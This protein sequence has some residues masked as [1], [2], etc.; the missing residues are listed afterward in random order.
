M[1]QLEI[2]KFLEEHRD[3]WKSLLTSDPYNLTIR[4]RDNFIL[5]MY[6]QIDSD[7]N[8]PLVCECRG[9]ILEKDTFKVICFPFTKFWNAQEGK[10]ASLDWATAKVQEK[11]DGS[12]LKSF[13]YDG[14]WRFS[15]M[16]MIDASECTLQNDL[17]NRYPTFYSLFMEGARKACLNFDRLDKN[18]TYMFE[19]VSPYNRVVVPY[20]EIEIYHTGT[21][22]N[23]TLEELEVDIGVK[24]PKSYSFSNEA[25]VLDMATHLP[26]SEEGYVVV[27]ANWNRVKV[28][29]PAYVAIHH[30][31]NNGDINKKRAL[32]IIMLNEHF[33]F[34]SYFKEYKEFFD[35][36]EDAL[37]L[38]LSKVKADI[39][40]LEGKVFPTK[41][42]YAMI[43]KEMTFPSL[44][45]L[46]YDGRVKKDGWEKYIRSLPADKVIEYLKLDSTVKESL[47]IKE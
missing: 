18:C 8:I 4:E 47:E 35:K 1:P 34:L 26:F 12:I 41:K 44:M 30:L 15:T 25:E 22:N 16:S 7:F 32:A 19:L 36:I 43:A 23:L 5:F 10:A 40:S 27:D 11:V 45:F 3:N 14:K 37:K 42:D 29:G 28:K 6:S 20:S 46:M 17:D 38:Y 9:L 21:R 13:W 2:Q 33:E 31:K 39:D 24:K